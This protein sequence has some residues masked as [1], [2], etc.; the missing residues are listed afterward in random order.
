MEI[1]A[2][3]TLPGLDDLAPVLQPTAPRRKRQRPATRLP[4][5]PWLSVAVEETLCEIARDICSHEDWMIGRGVHLQTEWGEGACLCGVVRH[6]WLP[7]LGS[8]PGPDLTVVMLNI[9]WR[10]GD[11]KDVLPRSLCV[12]YVDPRFSSLVLTRLSELSQK[13]DLALEFA[14]VAPW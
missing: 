4:V 1:L 10:C 11:S 14:P 13:T 8:L 3:G 6:P 9:P 12:T 7:G 5:V 2:Q